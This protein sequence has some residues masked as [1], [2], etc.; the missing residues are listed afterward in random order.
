LPTITAPA[1]R[2]AATLAPSRS[3]RNPSNSGEP[4]W[5]GMSAVSMMSLMPAGMPSIGEIWL[6]S[7]QRFVDSSAA[8]RAASRL[9]ATKAPTD[10]S[11]ASRDSRQ[12]SRK[13]RGESLPSANFSVAGK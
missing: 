8:A 11:Q 1:S 4:F 9:R 12:R 3:L 10:G 6:P 5:V 7:R 13:A 2:S